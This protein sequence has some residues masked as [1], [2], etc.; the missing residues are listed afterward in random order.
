MLPRSPANV[1]TVVT[2]LASSQLL[3]T[4]VIFSD[5]ASV[6]SYWTALV[7]CQFSTKSYCFC[8]LFSLLTYWEDPAVVQILA[9]LLS[10]MLVTAKFSFIWSFRIQPDSSALLMDV[11][12]I[13]VL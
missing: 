12:G 6:A 3:A 9:F 11:T 1:D 5:V 2:Q 4:V 10:Q 13:Y 7:P 8:C